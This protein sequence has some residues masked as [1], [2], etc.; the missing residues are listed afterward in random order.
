VLSKA[1]KH[2]QKVQETVVELKK[3]VE[4]LLKEKDPEKAQELFD[5]VDNL[6]RDAD[7]L[8]RETLMDISKG[9]LHPSAR[10]DLSHLIKR[11]DDV[12]NCATGVARRITT[13]PIKFWDQSS[14]LTINLILEMMNLTID[15]VGYLDKIVINL[16]GD[17]KHV[18]EYSKKISFLEHEVDISNIKLRKSL[19]ETAYDV[20]LF[21]IFTAGSVFDILEAI[22][23]A[24][25][26]V[27]D[28]IMVLLSSAKV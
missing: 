17:R 5:N 24:I 3:G 11:I 14:E 9:E 25:E 26:V 23:D 6:E 15:C 8:R 18:E 7:F 2:G 27:G 22:S 13:I 28:Y 12:A 10:E 1:I 21:T 19:Q 16:L 4:M 20:N